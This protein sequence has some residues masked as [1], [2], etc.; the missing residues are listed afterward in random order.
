MQLLDRSHRSPAVPLPAHAADCHMHVFGPFDRFPLAA[1]RA[2][3][4]PQASLA[5]HQRMKARV[6]LERTVLV[7]ASGHGTDNRAMLAALAELGP[8]GRGVAVVAPQTPLADLQRMHKAGVRGVRL[9]LY[10]FAAR[11]PGEPAALFRAYERLVA[12]LGWHVQL[13]CEPA[14]LL[15]L[16]GAIE[17][18]SVQ[19]VIDHMGLPD[20]A[21]GIDQ[22]VFQCLLALAAGGHAWAKLSGADRIARASGNL[23][24]A[25]PF[26]RALAQAAPQRLVWGSDWPNIGFHSREQVR[27]DH[28]LPHR[29]LDAGE[30]LDL[31]AEAVPNADSRHAILVRNPEALY[32]FSRTSS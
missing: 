15:A 19:V 4:V 31:L 7:Q 32:A 22:P 21:P 5:A 23:R 11:H 14:I 20:A 1:E 8:R 28:L 17:R 13:F 25:L 24:E 30:L 16:A 18:A 27:D 12:P 2:Y 6:G 26:M 10:T 9:N 29:E 3:N